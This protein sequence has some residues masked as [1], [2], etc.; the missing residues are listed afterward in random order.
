MPST[1]GDWTWSVRPNHRGM[2][3]RSAASRAWSSS[4]RACRSSCSAR[5][6]DGG[7]GLGVGRQI[8]HV[9]QVVVGGKAAL[10]E[11]QGQ[12]AGGVAGDGHVVLAVRHAGEQVAESTVSMV[13][14]M[15]ASASSCCIRAARRSGWRCRPGCRCARRIL[16][17]PAGPSPRLRPWPRSGRCH[18]PSPGSDRKPPAPPGPGRCGGTGPPCPEPGSMARR[19]A[20]LGMVSLLSIS[21]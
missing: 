8:R 2:K 6:L 4:T 15:P 9:E 5:P 18:T 21:S 14:V 20:A 13:T 1:V 19:T 16:P 10:G 3:G 11:P 12:G 17:R 7:D